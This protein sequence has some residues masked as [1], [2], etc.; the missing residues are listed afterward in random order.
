MVHATIGYWSLSDSC[1]SLT[2]ERN[3]VES[4]FKSTWS[5]PMTACPLSY[6]IFSY[7]HSYASL[8]SAQFCPWSRHYPSLIMSTLILP[9]PAITMTRLTMHARTKSKNMK[10]ITL[11]KYAIIK[12]NTLKTTLKLRKFNRCHRLLLCSDQAIKLCSRP[13]MLWM[14]L[15]WEGWVRCKEGNSTIY[16][17]RTCC[18]LRINRPIYLTLTTTI[19][20]ELK[21]MK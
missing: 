10:Y 19:H 3:V 5:L 13:N 18:G 16:R 2:E 8:L 11:Q 4:F 9:C 21:T 17:Q 14:H 12:Q 20:I 15:R 6:S 1:L 7:L